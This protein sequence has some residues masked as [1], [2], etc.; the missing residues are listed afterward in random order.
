MMQV[1]VVP[2]QKWL[3]EVHEHF[4]SLFDWGIPGFMTGLVSAWMPPL[5]RSGTRFD[6]EKEQPRKPM[7]DSADGL[8]LAGLTRQKA[9]S[10]N[11]I[12]DS[13][14]TILYLVLGQGWHRGRAFPNG[15]LTGAEMQRPGCFKHQ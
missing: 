1:E 3:S 13:A 14:A 11:V 5:V 10:D 6:A 9:V 4:H 8:K 15:W 12:G 2:L 7:I